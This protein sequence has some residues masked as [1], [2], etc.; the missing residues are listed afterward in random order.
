MRKKEPARRKVAQ[1]TLHVQEPLMRRGE[2]RG[3]ILVPVL[4][5]R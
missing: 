5:E 2:K 3:K 4:V 1:L